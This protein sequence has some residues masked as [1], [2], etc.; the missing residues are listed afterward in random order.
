M[1]IFNECLILLSQFAHQYSIILF[2]QFLFSFLDQLFTNYL[3]LTDRQHGRLLWLLLLVTIMGLSLATGALVR[4]LVLLLLITV[5]LLA[6]VV[7]D[8]IFYHASNLVTNGR[9]D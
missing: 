4:I 6:L 9:Q 7:D 1:C 2:S 8:L 5:L 3:S